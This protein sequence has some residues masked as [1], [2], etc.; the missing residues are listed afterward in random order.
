LFTSIPI[1]IYGA[2]DQEYEKEILL[3]NPELYEDGQLNSLFNKKIFWQWV[4]YSALSSALIF[5]CSFWSMENAGKVL[6]LINTN[7]SSE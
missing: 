4:I 1:I 3:K 2:L 5:F 6:F 7:N